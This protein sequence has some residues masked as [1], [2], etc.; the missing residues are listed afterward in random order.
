MILL[1]KAATI[2]A[3][4]G[5][6]APH[7]MILGLNRIEE[8]RKYDLGACAL[9]VGYVHKIARYLAVLKKSGPLTPF[10]IG[11]LEGVLNLVAPSSLWKETTVARE[12]EA[13]RPANPRRRTTKPPRPTRYFKYVEKEPKTQTVKFEVLAWLPGNEPYAFCYIPTG[14]PPI[15]VTEHQVQTSLG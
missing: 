8:A 11:E 5:K 7:R 4:L 2:E 12:P 13:V 15:F 6:S 9:I 10:S 14:N 1:E 3:L